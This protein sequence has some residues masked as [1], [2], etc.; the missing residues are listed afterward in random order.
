VDERSIAVLLAP[1]NVDLLPHVVDNQ[2]VGLGLRI[3]PYGRELPQGVMLLGYGSNLEEALNE[4]FQ[5]AEEGRWEPLDWRARPWATSVPA[6]V[7][8]FGKAKAPAQTSPS[9]PRAAKT[10]H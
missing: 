2:L 9:G 3:R 1:I 8:T 10:N 7:S 6:N 5:L 4:V